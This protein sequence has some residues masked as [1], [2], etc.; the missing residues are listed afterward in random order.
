MNK[1]GFTI[2][3]VLVTLIILSMIA[4]ISSNILQSSLASESESELEYESDLDFA[5]GPLVSC[6]RIWSLIQIYEW[7]TK[8][9]S[10]SKSRCENESKSDCQAGHRWPATA[11]EFE[12]EYRSEIDSESNQISKVGHQWPA[13][14]PELESKCESETKFRIRFMFQS[15]PTPNAA[16]PM[17]A[18]VVTGPQRKPHFCD[19]G[20]VAA[21]WAHAAHIPFGV[22]SCCHWSLTKTSL[23][24][25][26]YSRDG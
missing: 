23:L 9:E 16:W 11:S 14:K 24:R 8:S 18:T 1:N 5:T 12:Y 13:A 2:I 20:T 26:C 17:E 3:E 15:A 4:V 22:N 6:C 21:G 25:F 7:G 19:L 10:N